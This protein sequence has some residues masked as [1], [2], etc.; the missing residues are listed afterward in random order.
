M[1][2][3]LLDPFAVAKEFPETL[4][5]SL[6][7]GRSTCIKTNRRGDYI[8]SGTVD[9]TIVIIDLDTNNVIKVLRDHIRAVTS[10]SWS[11]CG[12]YLLSSSRDWKVNLWDLKEFK[13]IRSL[14]FN[15]P[16]WSASI[17]PEDKFKFV[18]SLL[19]DDPVYV[20]LTNENEYKI[21]KL[22]TDPLDK[23]NETVAENENEN[24]NGIEN[25]EENEIE[26]SNKKRKTNKK[27]SN[28]GSRKTRHWTLCSI[29]TPN[30]KLIFNGTSKGFINIF[31]I[32]DLKLIFS[33]K[34]SNSNI[35]NIIISENCIRFA[36]N[37]SD[38]IVRQFKFPLKF[39]DF[40]NIDTENENENNTNFEVFNIKDETFEFEFELEHKYQDV[41]NRIQWNSVKFNHDSE[42][43]CASTW[44]STHDIYIWETTMG[45]LVKILEGP[46]EELVEVDWNYKK[47]SILATGVDSG[48][49][50]IWSNIIPQKWSALAT[51]FEE[52]EE[53]ID[54]EE[55]EDEFDL[56]DEDELMNKQLED[57]DQIVDIISREK[58]DPRGFPILA[59]SCFIIDV[60]LEQE[61]ILL[62][63]D[64]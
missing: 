57:E 27:N 41:V 50:Y 6:S 4:T 51:D 18:A 36:I 17:H 37:S 15:C 13:I 11:N 28:S 58:L 14:N 31:R 20:D 10:I 49:I 2:L 45:S 44:G 61:E 23:E 3:S 39:W 16:I 42:Y 26:S 48:I 64:D 46:N 59:D 29:F 30:S 33:F 47:C 32:S 34:I 60:N 52:I 25:N 38:R 35:K 12:R 8:A 1:N 22:Q 5:Q 55:K 56:I 24:G 62:E 43:I 19:E 40:F 54:Y 9:G 63:N 21:V 53:N 7:F